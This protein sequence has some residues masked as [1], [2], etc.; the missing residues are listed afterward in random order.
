MVGR[1]EMARAARL[2][3]AAD[4]PREEIG[5]EL[6]PIDRAFRDRYVLQ[7]RVALGDSVFTA[8]YEEGR[9]LS[10]EKAITLALEESANA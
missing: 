3:G 8:A 1:G 2:F 7:S 6:E 10:T 5:F 4:V 9:A